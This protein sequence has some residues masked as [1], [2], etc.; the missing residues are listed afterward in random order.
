M[1]IP[2]ILSIVKNSPTIRDALDTYCDVIFMHAITGDSDLRDEIP[3][4]EWSVE[5]DGVFASDASGSEFI[6]L[7][8]GSVGF[9]SSEGQADRIAENADDFLRLLIFCPFWCDLTGV[10]SLSWLDDRNNFCD[11]SEKE[12]AEDYPDYKEKQ[13]TLA[14]AFGITDAPSALECAEKMYAASVREPRFFGVF[15]DDGEEYTTDSLFCE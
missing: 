4:T 7:A 14:A 12:Y 9:A 2:E 13:M 1:T 5:W 11:E 15:H 10:R 6:R 8:D 3:D